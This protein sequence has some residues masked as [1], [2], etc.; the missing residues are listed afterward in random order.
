MRFNELIHDLEETHNYVKVILNCHLYGDEIMNKNHPSS[1]ANENNPSFYNDK[2]LFVHN[3]GVLLSQTRENI[4]G[5]KLV[6][7][8]TV[9]VL[10][11]DTD[12]TLSVN[13]TADSYTAIVYDVTK[14]IIYD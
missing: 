9:M 12:Y 1:K 4:K 11:R 8:N 7:V 6:D 2:E 3:L 14:R 10:Y 5:C 13:I